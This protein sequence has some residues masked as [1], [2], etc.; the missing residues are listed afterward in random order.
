[1]DTNL[2]NI[3]YSALSL[4]E[5][6][7]YAEWLNINFTTNHKMCNDKEVNGYHTPIF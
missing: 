7:V 3:P 5:M 2:D 6:F 1:M 4:Q